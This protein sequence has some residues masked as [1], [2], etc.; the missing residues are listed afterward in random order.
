MYMSKNIGCFVLEINNDQHKQLMQ[1]MNAVAFQNDINFS[2]FTLDYNVILGSQKYFTVLPIYEAKYYFG[3]MFVFDLASLD[4]IVRFPNIE[5]ILYYQND[6][7]PWVL[8]PNVPKAVWDKLFSNNK[9][10]VLTDKLS[11]KQEMDNRFSIDC[12]LLDAI[13]PEALYNVVR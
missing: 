5:E 6:Q 12:S 9:I 2:V 10:K 13:T 11:V 8:N 4:L 7:Y 3:K 1:L